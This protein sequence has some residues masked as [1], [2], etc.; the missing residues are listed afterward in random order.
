MAFL[1][2]KDLLEKKQLLDSRQ[3]EQVAISTEVGDFLFKVPTREDLNDAKAYGDSTGDDDRA[4]DLLIYTAAIEPNL[5]DEELQKGL[6][7]S[8]ADPIDVI[9]AVFKPGEVYQI[10]K[11]L[12]NRAGYDVKDVKAR[13]AVKN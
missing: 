5:K 6:L 4:D 2:A 10:A 11:E 13:D 12:M 9:H 8:N 3:D 7:G 1:S